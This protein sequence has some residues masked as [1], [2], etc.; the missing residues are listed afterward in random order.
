MVY[1]GTKSGLNDVLY[2]PWFALPTVDT[3][4]RW[5]IAGTWLADNDYGDCFLNYPLHPDLQK[6]C[7]INLSQLFAKIQLNLQAN[8][9][10]IFKRY[11]HTLLQNTT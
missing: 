2:A 9:V 11:T 7:G 5:V 1:D 3:M 4:T 6:F 10:K 8:I